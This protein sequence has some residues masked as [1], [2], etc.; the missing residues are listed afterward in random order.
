MLGTLGDLEKNK[1]D[2]IHSNPPYYQSK[3]MMEAAKATGY[4][5]LNGAVVESLFLEWILKSLKPGETANI[6]LPDGIF[7]K[8]ANRKL[9]EYILNN[10]FVESIISLPVC[11]YF[12]TLK[13]TYI[14]TVRKETKREKEENKQQDYPVFT[15]IATSIGESLDVYR[16]DIEENSLYAAVAKYNLKIFI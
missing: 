2:L 5:D 6:V 14:L 10:F 4:Y 16:F 13:N 12:N 7:S 9:K 11:S 3:V 8:Y 15:Y 1:Y